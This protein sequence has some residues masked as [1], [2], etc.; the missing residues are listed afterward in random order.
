MKITCDQFETLM[1]F[2]MDNDLK[3]SIKEAFEEHLETCPACRQKYEAFKNI[4]MDLRES[5]KKFSSGDTQVKLKNKEE[6]TLNTSISAYI[7]NEL[8]IQENIKLKKIIISKPDVRQKLENIISLKELLKNSFEK[9]RPEEDFSRKILKTMYA[10][11]R[12]TSNKDILFA[13]VSFILLSCV[14]AVMLI[15]AIGG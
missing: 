3:P 14:W 8:D 1:H 9:T 6:H 4:I 15:S 7:D 11:S 5:Y 10:P 12:K 2:Y 13:L